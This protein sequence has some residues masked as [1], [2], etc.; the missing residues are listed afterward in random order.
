M[1]EKYKQR[2]YTKS[3]TVYYIK[4][5]DDKLKKYQVIFDDHSLVKLADEIDL[6]CRDIRREGDIHGDK[7]Y[8]YYILHDLHYGYT[9]AIYILMDYLANVKKVEDTTEK[10]CLI[11]QQEIIRLMHNKELDTNEGIKQLNQIQNQL[12]SFLEHREINKNQLHETE[13]FQKIRDTIKLELIAEVDLNTAITIY[14]FFDEWVKED[15]KR[16]LFKN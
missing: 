11:K 6:R 8:V 2:H 10:D 9:E 3:S 16:V 12:N 5:E 14:N 7:P 1:E 15:Y 4:I 13:Y